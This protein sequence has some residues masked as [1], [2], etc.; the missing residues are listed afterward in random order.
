MA[1][2][3]EDRRAAGSKAWDPA[4]ASAWDPAPASASASA[5]ALAVSPTI[6]FD[7]VRNSNLD[8]MCV[9]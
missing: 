2:L 9:L 3:S 1:A 8:F 7:C 5:P 4:S 6:Q